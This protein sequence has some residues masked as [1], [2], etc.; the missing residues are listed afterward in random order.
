VSAV[1][2]N[3]EEFDGQAVTLQGWVKEMTSRRGNGYTTFKIQSGGAVDVLKWGSPSIKDGDRVRV[4]GTFHRVNHVGPYT[5]YDQIE[6]EKV[7]LIIVQ[8]VPVDPKQF[9]PD[10]D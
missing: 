10:R 6:A 8:R 3:P 9:R 4:E 7:W 5:F 2:Q 1:I